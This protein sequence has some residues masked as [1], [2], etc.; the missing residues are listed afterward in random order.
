MLDSLRG[1]L[2]GSRRC[3]LV[4]GPSVQPSCDRREE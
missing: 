2:R 3:L 1:S 4:T